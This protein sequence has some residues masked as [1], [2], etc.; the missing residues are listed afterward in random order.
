M[1]QKKIEKNSLIVSSTINLLMA[2]AGIWVFAAT[3]IHALFLDGVFSLIGCLSNIFA[4]IL[5]TVSKKRTKTYPDGMYF[6]EPLYAILKSLL[7][8]M[9]MAVS[10]IGTAGVAYGY[11]VSGIGEV[12]NVEPVMP[13]TA[14][15]VVLCFWLSFYNKY[16]NKKIGNISTILTAES[17]SNF[18]DGVLSL[19][20]GIAIVFL[21]FI[22]IDGNLSF[23]HYTGD[24]FVTTILCLISLKT[25]IIV[26]INSFKELSGGITDDA[27]IKNNVKE[28]MSTYFDE[29]TAEVKYKVY[30]VGMHVKIR[31]SLT[32]EINKDS[33]EKLIYARNSII[34]ELKT[35]YDSVE[36]LFVF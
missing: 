29:I 25:P 18:V 1:T 35:S 26:I 8:L 20:V 19:G 6:V 33:L 28:V 5:A 34:K 22:D 4:I 32:Y 10:I 24:F 12:M 16:Q 27:D 21:K 13:Y 11:F 31:I 3:N 7:T 9:L 15:M 14:L 2:G 17:K 36:V 30:K 23:L